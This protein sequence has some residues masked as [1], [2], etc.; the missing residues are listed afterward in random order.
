MK[1]N[2]GA[3]K[4]NVNISFS[5]SLIDDSISVRGKKTKMN[6]EAENETSRVSHNFKKK[7]KQEKQ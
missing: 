1:N 7:E 3:V 6:V 4:P 2:T 5:D